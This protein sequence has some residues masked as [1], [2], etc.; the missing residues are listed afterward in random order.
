MK[1]QTYID[2]IEVVALMNNSVRAKTFYFGP[3]LDAEGKIARE[4]HD[5]GTVVMSMQG[6][7]S[8]YKAFGELFNELVAKGVLQKSEKTNGELDKQG[9]SLQKLEKTDPKS[10]I[11]L[12]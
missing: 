12:E 8:A 7:L 1:N 10:V 5:A 11:E 6:F 2:G 9:G 4:Q 3:K